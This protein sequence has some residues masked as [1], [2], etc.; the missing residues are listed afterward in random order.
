MYNNL[1]T[2][3]SDALLKLIMAAKNNVDNNRIM[4]VS[5]ARSRLI[6]RRAKQT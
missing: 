2:Q 6:E 4:T 3:Q 5:E 1:K